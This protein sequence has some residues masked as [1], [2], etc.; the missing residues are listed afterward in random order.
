MA[1][2]RPLCDGDLV[3]DSDLRADEVDDLGRGQGQGP[4]AEVLP[5]RV[6]GVGSDLD[7]MELGQG[8][9]PAHALQV[10]G[11]PAA[12]D[13][14]RGQQRDQLGVDRGIDLADVRIQIDGS[15]AA[16]LINRIVR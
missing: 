16:S 4:A 12:G 13:A 8:D 10:S 1:Q 15:H 9:C 5:V 14:G 2:D 7:P 3:Q 11:V 6:A